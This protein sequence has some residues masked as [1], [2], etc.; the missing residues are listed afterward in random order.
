M[1]ASAHVTMKNPAK[2]QTPFDSQ[3]LTWFR[4]TEEEYF[5]YHLFRPCYV[6]G[7]LDCTK[8]VLIPRTKRVDGK[9]QRGFDVF[10]PLYCYDVGQWNLEL[11]KTKDMRKI[12]TLDR[13]AI[14]IH[15]GWIP[16]EL[17]DKRKRLWE[18]TT[19]QLVKYQGFMTRSPNVH[20][21]TTPNDH[22]NNEWH[23]ASVEDMAQYWALPN[24]NE[25]KR[26]YFQVADLDSSVGHTFNNGDVVYK[27]PRPSTTDEI[28]EEYYK[29]KNNEWLNKYIYYSLASL[30][31]VSWGLYI[32]TF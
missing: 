11:M 14:V 27:W 20:D 29:W 2:N 26:F 32:I 5:F 1:R 10:N 9:Y 21:Y 7:Q 6:V 24:M 22:T 13:A 23:H 25:L 17:K 18:K 30:S 15:R 12:L 31:V 19:N 28:I 8:E 16:Y 4:M 3:W